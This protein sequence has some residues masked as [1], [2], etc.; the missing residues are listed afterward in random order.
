MVPPPAMSDAVSQNAS[1][2]RRSSNRR[3]AAQDV[4]DVAMEKEA[5][6]AGFFYGRVVWFDRYPF[7]DDLVVSKGKDGRN[8]A[9][10]KRTLSWSFSRMLP[11]LRWYLRNNHFVFSV[12]MAHPLNPLGALERLALLIAACGY[13]CWVQFL[14]EHDAE[15]SV[16]EALAELDAAAGPGVAA[17][18]AE[19]AAMARALVRSSLV[20]T[21][22]VGGVLLTAWELCAK[23][24]VLPPC[25]SREAVLTPP[26][27]TR[28]FNGLGARYTHVAV[29]L[30]LAGGGSAGG[31][32]MAQS[33][34]VTSLACN[35]AAALS[36]AS[37]LSLGTDT[38][39]FLAKRAEQLRMFGRASVFRARMYP[40]GLARPRRKTLYGTCWRYRRLADGPFERARN[41][42]RRAL[43]SRISQAMMV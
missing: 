30:I 8:V 2:R 6:E 1:A 5:L 32:A 11:D 25:V 40:F 15:A 24:L 38:L 35:A 14:L 20:V 12:F 19:S 41:Y 7:V 13:A 26:S 36:T 33:A 4:Q 3:S 43:V 16:R 9:R 42:G 34:D 18:D 22:W 21:I 28:A 23:M 31:V 10:W 27:Y 17:S 29:L 39:S 37:L